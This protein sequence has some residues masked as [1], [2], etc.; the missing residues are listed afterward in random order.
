MRSTDQ[1]IVIEKTVCYSPFPRARGMPHPGGPHREACGH[2]GD[3]RR[4]EMHGQ[5]PLL[6]FCGK[7]R[8]DKVR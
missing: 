4:K 6:W 3:R 8:Q 2:L 1:M 5:E 7:A